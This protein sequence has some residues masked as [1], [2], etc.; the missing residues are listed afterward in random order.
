MSNNIEN[1]NNGTF[2]MPIQ[3]QQQE[4]LLHPNHTGVTIRNN[5]QQDIPKIV[6]LQQESFPYLARYGNI[7]RP[8]ELESHLRVFQKVNL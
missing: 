5:L 1:N 6:S 7:W 4:S 3:Q 2:S 8:E